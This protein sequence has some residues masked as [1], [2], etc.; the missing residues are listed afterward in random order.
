MSPQP[1]DSTQRVRCRSHCPS[2]GAHFTSDG[3]F[4]AH[5]A[6]SH[7]EGDRH[8]LDPEPVEGL[9]VVTDS[10]RCEISRPHSEGIELWEHGRHVDAARRRSGR[11][12]A[13]PA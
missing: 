11:G 5:R 6:G 9:R 12:V 8:C 4:D 7:R 10:G 1:P 3:A 13:V 2:C